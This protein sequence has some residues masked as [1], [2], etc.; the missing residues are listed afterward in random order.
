[1]MKL[2]L[3]GSKIGED[4]SMIE[5]QIIQDGGSGLVMHELGAL[6]AKGRVVLVGLDHEEG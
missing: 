6:V 1:M 2:G 4:V 3:Y 5:L